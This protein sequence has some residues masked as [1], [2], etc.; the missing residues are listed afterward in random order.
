MTVPTY[1]R[2]PTVRDLIRCP[3]PSLL[4]GRVRSVTSTSFL[5]RG[6]WVRP[7]SAGGLLYKVLPTSPSIGREKHLLSPLIALPSSDRTIPVHD[8]AGEGMTS[9]ATMLRRK[10]HL[11]CPGERLPLSPQIAS[12]LQRVIELARS[13]PVWPVLDRT[14]LTRLSGGPDVSFYPPRS[15][16]GS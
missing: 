9:R 1:D 14:T 13:S 11:G 15:G 4:H 10:K 12:R 8:F 6:S 3:R 7:S 5:P 16:S 2:D